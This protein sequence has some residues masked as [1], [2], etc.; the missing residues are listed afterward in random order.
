MDDRPTITTTKRNEAYA[1]VNDSTDEVFQF[2]LY[3]WY[4]TNG[5][6]DKLLSIDS[7]YVIAFLTRESR[8]SVERADLLW[9]FYVYHEDF[10]NAAT[11][12][13]ELAK[14]QF[15][16]PLERRIEYLS[17]AKANASAQSSGIG[18]QARQVLLYEI[19]EL[20]DVANV[21]D[22]ILH[23]LK[24]ETRIQPARKAEAIAQL[25][26]QIQPIDLVDILAPI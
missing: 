16:I 21:Q 6:I 3:D 22:E 8:N 20:L 2:D 24:G 23:R 26:D 18:R 7:H 4:L 13:L 9:K 25:D 5:W 12:Q 15:K 14:S 1:V 19:T 17:R 10:F 11:V